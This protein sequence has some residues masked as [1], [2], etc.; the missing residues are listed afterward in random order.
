[1]EAFVT[2]EV[3]ETPAALAVLAA[4]RTPSYLDKKERKLACKT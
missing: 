1:V 4:R 3:K 2:A